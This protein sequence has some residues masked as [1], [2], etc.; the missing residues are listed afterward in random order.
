[1]DVSDLRFA[2]Q[3]WLRVICF[4]FGLRAGVLG[5]FRSD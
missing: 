1:M 3:G 2:E 5:V 4:P